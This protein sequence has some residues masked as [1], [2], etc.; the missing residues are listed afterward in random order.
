MTLV[1]LSKSENLATV[2]DKVTVFRLLQR[3]IE[4]RFARRLGFQAR[5]AYFELLHPE[6]RNDCLICTGCGSIEPLEVPPVIQ[7]VESEILRKG[8]QSV[9]H[10]LEFFGICPK[11]A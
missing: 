11:C 1:E 7:E 8:F 10:E 4:R 9:Y 5:G 3:L 6:R 2:C